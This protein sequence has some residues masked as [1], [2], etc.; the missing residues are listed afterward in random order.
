[1]LAKIGARVERLA[2]RR[3]APAHA[4]QQQLLG[5]AR[6]H[7][8]AGAHCA[9]SRSPAIS[10]PT[11]PVQ[12]EILAFC[13]RAFDDRF[14]ARPLAVDGCGIP[15]FATPLASAAR[16]FARF[17]TLRGFADGDRRALERCARDAGRALDVAGSGRFDT[18]LMTAGAGAIVAKGGAEGVA[19]ERAACVAAPGSC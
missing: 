6:R 8:G 17:A 13:E 5:Q 7:L 4:L 3:S 1:M 14:T 11:H 10:T 2:V 12:R 16:A 9:A 19:R 15:A 18:D